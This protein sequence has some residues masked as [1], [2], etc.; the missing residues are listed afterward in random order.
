MYSAVL[1]VHFS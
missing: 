1:S